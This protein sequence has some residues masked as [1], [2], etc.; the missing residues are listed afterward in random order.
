MFLK[1]IFL[2]RLVHHCSLKAE[3]DGAEERLQNC[4]QGHTTEGGLQS[5]RIGISNKKRQKGQEREQ[6]QE[7]EKGR[8]RRCNPRPFTETVPVA[9]RVPNG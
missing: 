8:G 6:G 4:W 5:S 1:L 3:T 7:G 9:V 2:F